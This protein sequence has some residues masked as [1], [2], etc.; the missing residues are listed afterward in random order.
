MVTAVQVLVPEGFPGNKPEWLVF[1]QLQRMGLTPGADFDF[2]SSQLGGRMERG[3]TVLDFYIPA[4][5]IALNVASL[6]WHYGR[7]DQVANDVR[8]REELEAQGIRVVYL[9]EQDIYANA[10]FY[11]SE[12]L[13]GIDHSRVTR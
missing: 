2:Q 9:D 1:Q 10:E 8:Q 5:G 3:G 13:K 6:Y 7:P 11:V 4:L 12:A